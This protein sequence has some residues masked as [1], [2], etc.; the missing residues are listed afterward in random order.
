MFPL[1]F[2]IGLEDRLFRWRIQL[3]FEYSSPHQLMNTR[4]YSP[5]IL[6]CG[7]SDKY[8][9]EGIP[10]KNS[11]RVI[12]AVFRTPRAQSSCTVGS[13]HPL[14][15]PSGRDLDPGDRLE[16]LVSVR[17]R[18]LGRVVPRW[19]RVEGTGRSRY[20]RIRY[21]RS[22]SGSSS[23]RITRST[24]GGTNSG[25][26][27]QANPESSKTSDQCFENYETKAV[28]TVNIGI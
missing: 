4:G 20:G 21:G 14:H 23:T 15:R 2:R 16:R 25:S 17:Q 28:S 13:R 19:R 6:P 7:V 3:R 22:R 26:T 18:G 5:A 24:M 10:S 1:V 27:R 8:G 11:G 12:C 9:L